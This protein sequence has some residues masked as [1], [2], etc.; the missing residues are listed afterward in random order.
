MATYQLDVTINIDHYTPAL[1]TV[2]KLLQGLMQMSISHS[3]IMQLLIAL[4]SHV[5]H[6]K[7]AA[8]SHVL[9]AQSDVMHLYHKLNC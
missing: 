8:Y 5:L 1:T 6:M 2:Q 3:F 7:A 9:C 4:A